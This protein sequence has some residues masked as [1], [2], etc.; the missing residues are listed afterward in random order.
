MLVGIAF[1]ICPLLLTLIPLYCANFAQAKQIC[2]AKT[3][4]NL[5]IISTMTTKQKV[6]FKWLKRV[7]Y[8]LCHIFNGHKNPQ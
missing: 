5:L 6:A 4:L 7:I 3:L 8:W 1:V 2:K